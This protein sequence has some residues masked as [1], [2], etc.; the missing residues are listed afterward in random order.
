MNKIITFDSVGKKYGQKTV[1]SNISF[2]IYEQDIIGLLGPSG[3]GKTTILKLISGLEKPTSGKIFVSSKKI[4]YVFQEPR[5]FPW[6]TAIENILLPLMVSGHSKKEAM[7]IAKHYL[8]SMGLSEFMD[9]YPAKLSGGMR[10]RVSLA[11]ALS[12]CPDILLLDEPF[13]ALDSKR[14]GSLVELLAKSIEEYPMVVL[15]V[16]HFPEEAKK[17]ANKIHTLSSKD[18]LVESNL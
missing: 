9:Y 14:K 2:S 3:I 13:S 18:K 11:R 6:K 5:L 10:Q 8:D 16:S 1:L 4:S 15:Y 12:L 17:I 7:N